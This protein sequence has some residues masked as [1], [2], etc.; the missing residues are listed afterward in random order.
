MGAL[1]SCAFFYYVF[2]G[3]YYFFSSTFFRIKGNASSVFRVSRLLH[4]VK[5]G[6][7]LWVIAIVCGDDVFLIH[8][9]GR[10][11]LSAGVV[12]TRNLCTALEWMWQQDVVP[13]ARH[14]ILQ[15]PKIIV[16]KCG[17]PVPPAYKNVKKDGLFDILLRELKFLKR[18]LFG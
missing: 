7:Y 1:G 11:G 9:L 14:H 10:N 4:E 13:K 16:H 2:G 3:E 15:V 12:F 5:Y 18:R 17:K 6:F 8:C